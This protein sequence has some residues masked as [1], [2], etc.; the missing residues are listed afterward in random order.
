MNNKYAVI[1][2][3]GYMTVP[4]DSIIV[5]RYDKEQGIIEE[6]IKFN[7]YQE[8]RDYLDRGGFL[9]IERMIRNL[10]YDEINLDAELEEELD[11]QFGDD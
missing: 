4:F 5:G 1:Q 8:V 2:L 3:S 9:L 10:S 6:K 7:D 11:L